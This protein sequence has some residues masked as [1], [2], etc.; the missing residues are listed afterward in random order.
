MGPEPSMTDVGTVQELATS[1]TASTF[2]TLCLANNLPA[3][4]PHVNAP[5][6]R[7]IYTQMWM[8]S[9]ESRKMVY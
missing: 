5:H 2:T 7:N 8:N 3:P 4:F 6:D 1:S 9:T